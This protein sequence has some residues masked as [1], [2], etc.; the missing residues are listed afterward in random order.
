MILSYGEIL[1]RLIPH[2]NQKWIDEANIQCYVGGAELNVAFALSKWGLP[3]A[4]FSAMP[5]HY[6]VD[7]ILVYMQ[8]H[9]IDTSRIIQRE[10]RLGTY[11]IP[12]GGDLKAAGVIY[13]RENTSF[14]QLSPEEIDFDIVFKDITWLHLSAICPALTKHTAEMALVIVTEAKARKI[15]VSID[16]NYR[17]KLWQY[18]E[19][20]FEIMH[21]ITQKCD[22]IMGNIWAVQ[23]L[24]NIGID[25]VAVAAEDYDT[26]AITCGNKMQAAYPRMKLLA[27]TY[28]FDADPSSATYTGVI[29]ADGQLTKSETVQIGEVRD[30]VGSGDCFMSGLIYGLNK[31]WS[32]KEIINFSSKAAVNKLGEYGDHT[33]TD[34][35]TILNK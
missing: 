1:L 33:D 10:G 6:L 23:S 25:E 15:T 17:A 8:N 9:K 13:D 14:A 11:Y 22:V 26:A 27:L 16:F 19:K 2:L 20:P 24:L 29:Y 12:K 3:V 18:G 7:E 21:K 5:N 30:K 28:R 32:H 34:V 35:E 31:G 4:S